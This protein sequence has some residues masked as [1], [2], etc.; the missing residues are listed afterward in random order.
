MTSKIFGYIYCF[1]KQFITRAEQIFKTTHNNEVANSAISNVEVTNDTLSRHYFLY[2]ELSEG[3]SDV[4][5]ISVK[6]WYSVSEMYRR[7]N[8]S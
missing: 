2:C 3:G 7:S 5:E 6:L 8:F 4:S 1:L